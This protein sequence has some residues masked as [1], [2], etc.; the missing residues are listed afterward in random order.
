LHVVT[1]QEFKS[2]VHIMVFDIVGEFV[3]GP[4]GVGGIQLSHD[5]FDVQNSKTAGE[6][7]TISE[8]GIS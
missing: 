1:S 4:D 7:S 2:N 5:I 8:T 3:R 6:Y